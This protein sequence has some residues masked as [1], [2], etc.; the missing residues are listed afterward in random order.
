MSNSIW[1]EQANMTWVGQYDMN[2]WVIDGRSIGCVQVYDVRRYMTWA[3]LYNVSS[4]IWREESY[5]ASQ[6]SKS[7]WCEQVNIAWEW[8][9]AMNRSVW[10]NRSIWLNV[11]MW[12]ELCDVNGLIWWDQINMTWTGQ[13]DVNSSIWREQANMMETVHM[14]WADQYD[15]RYV[16]CLWCE[17]VNMMG[18]LVEPAWSQLGGT[19]VG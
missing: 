16:T 8:Q 3:G 11:S 5:W 4:S 7:I 9:Y 13:C 1:C 12:P 19:S 18:G 10:L 2:R 6:L 15:V 14:T 17:L